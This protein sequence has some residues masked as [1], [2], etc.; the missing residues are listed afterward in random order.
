MQYC[1][2]YVVDG[3]VRSR[4]VVVVTKAKSNSF[5]D[6][7]EHFEVIAVALAVP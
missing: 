1:T 5:P 7:V 4:Q 3:C 2:R 6:V